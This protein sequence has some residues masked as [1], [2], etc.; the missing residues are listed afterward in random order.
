MEFLHPYWLF[1]LLA[2][3]VPVIIHLFN[4]RRYRKYYFT[5]LRLLKSI[6]KETKKQHRLRHLLILLSRILAIVF[7]VI[8]F[9]RPYV[10]GP[11]G[12]QRSEINR[13]SIYVDNSMSMQASVS[14]HSLLDEALS[15]ASEVVK[16]YGPSDR[17]QL[18]TNDFEGRHQ[19]YYNA[20]EISRLLTEV[21]ISPIQRTT[22]E[23]HER[24]SEL[25]DPQ[26]TDRLHFFIISDFQQSTTKLESLAKDTS[27]IVFLMPLIETAPP[28]VFIDSCWMASPFNHL[29][30]QQELMVRFRNTAGLDLEKI[31]VRLILN[32]RQRA[33][34][35][36]D[37]KAFEEAEVS[38]PFTQREAGIQI[39]EVNIDDYPITWDDHM[40]MAWEVKSSIPVL[41]IGMG[42]A[43]FYL[44]S[45]FSRDSLFDYTFND[46]RKLDY[47]RFDAMDFIVLDNVERISSGLANELKKYTEQ[48]GSIFIIPA[49]DA[50][51][52]SLNMMLA[53]FGTG[54]L[55]KVDTSKLMV[56]GLNTGHEL[57]SDVFE[58]MPRNPDLPVAL[59]H[60]PLASYRIAG[61]DVIMDLQNGDPYLVVSAFGKGK[62]YLLT[63]PAGEE[64]GNLVRHALWVPLIYRM[65]MLS[66]PMNK[67]YYTLGADQQI[68]IS[69]F[70]MTGDMSLRM[71]LQGSEYEFIPGTRSGHSSTELLLY[72]QVKN[73]GQYDLISD[74]SRIGTFAFNYDRKES[75]PQ[76]IGIDDLDLLARQSANNNMFIL[77]SDDRPVAQSVKELNQGKGLW[78]LFI[79]L[80]LLFILTEILLLRLFR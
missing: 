74:G 26:T 75:D 10:P 53:T 17:F 4:F 33:L 73:A 69:S 78:K 50:D 44:N 66:R 31:P 48:G 14:G 71:K 3:A 57:F 63:A 30:Q 41:V 35:S 11:R 56:T 13:V 55:A 65:A 25:Q 5:N 28:N 46:I 51:L 7:L 1:G 36:I 54:S 72:D 8:A 67:L 18:I 23:I 77:S 29:D 45:L 16:A 2:V 9:A 76:I 27:L 42:E 47:S 12:I 39:A 38:L 79:W 59:Q 60:Y 15:K 37:V 6:K 32:G 40:F 49:F 52:E 62:V 21:R 24:L 70:S 20:D 68:G 64:S 22:D 43:G 34:A 80:A 61:N 19:P 58:S